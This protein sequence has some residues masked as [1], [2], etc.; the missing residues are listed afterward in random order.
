MTKTRNLKLT[1][2]GE[3]EV[4]HYFLAQKTTTFTEK[5][6][7]IK[8][9]SNEKV[10]EKYFSKIDYELKRG[11]DNNFNSESTKT[12]RASENQNW[13]LG[14]SQK[15]GNFLLQWKP[16]RAEYKKNLSASVRNSF[17]SFSHR[18]PQQRRS[19]ISNK[20]GA[21]IY[22]LNTLWNWCDWLIMNNAIS[23]FAGR[24]IK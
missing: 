6:S 17:L 5:K 23:K 13:E 10:P 21:H 20:S 7:K 24:R 16:K 15:R 4:M 11:T 19:G 9:W 8:L 2:R 3:A 1:F 18:L 22:P 14:Q 12:Y